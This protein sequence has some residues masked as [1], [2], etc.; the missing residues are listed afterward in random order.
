MCLRMQMFLK[1]TTGLQPTTRI[2][3][4]GEV[5]RDEGYECSLCIIPY[6]YCIL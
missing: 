1:M 3:I 2:L 6:R 4:V 5:G